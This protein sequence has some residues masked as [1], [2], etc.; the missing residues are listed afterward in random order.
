MSDK[1]YVVWYDNGKSWEDNFSDISAA[2]ST[3]EEA[4]KMLP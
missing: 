2:F 4:E 1:I 3:R